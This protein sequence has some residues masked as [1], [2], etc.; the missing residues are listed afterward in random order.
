VDEQTIYED[1]MLT[2]TA[3]DVESFLE[4]A[5]AMFTKRYGRSIGADAIRPMFG[6]EEAYLKSSLVA[7]KDIQGYIHD[8]LGITDKEKAALKAAY[9]A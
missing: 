9:I 2:M 5:A 6:V 4:P 7:I 1:Y 8:E 3:V